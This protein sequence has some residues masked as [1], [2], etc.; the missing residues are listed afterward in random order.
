[1]KVKLT[2]VK[3]TKVNFKNKEIIVGLDVHHKI[4]YATIIIGEITISKCFVPRTDKL[5]EYLKKT[6]PEGK[7]KVGYEA[8]CFGYWIKEELDE[9]GIETIV[10]NPADIPT[11][12]KDRRTKTDKVDSKKIAMAI[13][14]GMVKGIYVP[15]KEA[16]EIRSL[17]RRRKELSKKSTRVKNQIKSILKFYGIQYPKAYEE[18][19]KHWSRNFIK[20]LGGL[21]FHT[22]QGK[23]TMEGYLRELEFIKQE[24]LITN[25]QLREITKLD[26]YKEKYKILRSIPGIGFMAAITILCELPEIERFKS[27]DDLLSYIGLSP[28]EHSSGEKR[29]IGHMTKRCNHLLRTTF[30]ESAWVAIRHD[31]AL[32]KYYNESV[33]KRGKQ[34]SI[35]KVAKKLAART[36]Y[37]LLNESEYIS[38]IVA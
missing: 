2:K 11:S 17:L 9:Y 24:I 19:G 29:K 25:R 15:S 7:Y 34:K 22:I 38:G 28:N 4:W 13:K 35:I 20:W 21:K 3:L 8:G 23:Q 1:M 16:Q 30:I 33:K 37:L 36:R 5:F 10:I 14:S 18:K 31:P 27:R 26:K 12:D 32:T 6:Y